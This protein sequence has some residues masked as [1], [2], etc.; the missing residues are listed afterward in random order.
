MRMKA[1]DHFHSGQTSPRTV[2]AGAEFE[3]SDAIGKELEERGLATPL[4]GG[5]SDPAPPENKMEPPP[6]NKVAKPRK[7]APPPP[8]AEP[9][10]E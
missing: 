5:K 6:V 4:E 3:T 10:G 1:T 7:T 9:A 2:R 8:P